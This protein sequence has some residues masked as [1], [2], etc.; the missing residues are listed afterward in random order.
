MLDYDIE[1]LFTEVYRMKKAYPHH[2][3]NFLSDWDVEAK[4]SVELK[5]ILKKVFQQSAQNSFKYNYAYEQFN[6]KIQFINSFNSELGLKEEQMTITP[7]ATTSI[8]LACKGLS[9]LNVNRILLITP[10]YFSVHESLNNLNGQIFYYNLKN[11]N[12]FRIDFT[13]LEYFIKEQFIQAIVLT[14]PVYSSGIEYL[15]EDYSLLIDICRK[16]KLYLV[17]D[18][19]LGGLRWNYS[20]NFLSSYEKI[21]ILKSYNQFAFIDTLPKR[22][23]LNGIKFSTIVGNEELI[24]KIDLASESIYGALNSV[25]CLLFQELYDPNNSEALN[26]ICTENIKHVKSNYNM[27]NSLLIGTPFNL[28]P[29]NSG[30][31]TI[32]NHTDKSNDSIDVKKFSLS[33]LKENKILC[34]TTDR[35]GYHP[36]NKFGFRINLNKPTDS[37]I[38]GI[39]E[40]IGIDFSRFY[41]RE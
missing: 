25:Q 32:I 8:Y 37:L 27:V 15:A 10:A 17:V 6:L 29:T 11:N 2:Q 26:K 34:L 18:Y 4:E 41:K 19:S 12:S 20:S 28:A 5:R 38:I 39:R 36:E 23:M 30:Y 35:F 1:W 33:L 21:S 3:I 9:L 31:F 22:L 40:T 24:D 7:S 16:Y 14:D 13:Y